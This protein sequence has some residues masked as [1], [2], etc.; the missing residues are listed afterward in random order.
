MF[1]SCPAARF[2]A[3]CVSMC[4]PTCTRYVCGSAG[5]SLSRQRGTSTHCMYAV[6]WALSRTAFM[7][8]RGHFHSSTLKAARR[9]L[10]MSVCRRRRS[11]GL[12]R[13]G[14]CWSLFEFVGVRVRVGR[15][16]SGGPCLRSCGPAVL[17]S[18]GPAGVVC[19]VM[20]SAMHA[21]DLAPP[22]S[23]AVPAAALAAAT[24]EVALEA[25]RWRLGAGGLALEAS[26]PVA[27][28]RRA[29]GAMLQCSTSACRS[30]RC[31][32]RGV[33][34]R[35]SAWHVAWRVSAVQ[36][37]GAAGLKR[38]AGLTL[39]MKTRVNARLPV[40]P[41]GATCWYGSTHASYGVSFS[42]EH[43]L[44]LN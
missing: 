21:H 5:T 15:S 9:H 44:R 16:L 4:M 12:Q 19:A 25:W 42:T 41:R 7:R 3:L 2:H 8:Q 18:C 26:W 17:L 40:A 43:K 29:L 6:A 30:W 20:L 34:R 37:L 1:V 23:A 11:A 39:K 13:V 38:G 33:A 22:M 31:S 28:R 14:V 32:W 35:G 36:A 27:V 24:R 10:G